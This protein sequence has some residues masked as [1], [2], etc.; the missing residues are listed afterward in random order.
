MI[1]M[2]FHQELGCAKTHTIKNFKDKAAIKTALPIIDLIDCIKPGVV[3]YTQVVDKPDSTDEVTFVFFNINIRP[4]YN[5]QYAISDQFTICN[6][7]YQE[8]LE[9]AKY[10]ISCGR[11]IGAP[12]FALPE[13]I[14]EVIIIM[15]MRR[16]I[17]MMMMMML[18]SHR[19]IE[20]KGD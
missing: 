19:L 11:K 5:T 2:T 9:N 15:K 20:E 6:M 16:R 18:I 10:A 3:D 14:V 12:V 7:Q 1:N 17:G 8:N 13:D 4:F